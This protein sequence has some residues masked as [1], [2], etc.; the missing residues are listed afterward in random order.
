M[1]FDLSALPI[2]PKIM[3]IIG[4]ALAVHLFVI[5]VRHLVGVMLSSQKT[6]RYRK[7]QSI[8]TIATSTLMFALYFLTI[9][10]ILREFGVSLSAYLASASVIGLAIGFGSQGVVQDV[11]SGLTFIF[12]DLV[13]VGDLV[14]VSGE[15][16]VVR[17]ITM[18]F[19]QL[20]NSYGAKVFIPNRT[21]S[22]LVNYPKGYIRSIADVTL[23]GPEKQ[24]KKMHEAA[25]IAMQ[26]TYEQYP[27]ILMRAPSEVGRVKLKSGKEILR[28]KFRIWP[29]RTDPIEKFFKEEVTAE[30]TKLDA[31]YKGWMISI[32]YEAEQRITPAKRLLW[33]WGQ[34]AK[35]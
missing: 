12:S 10:F 16:G 33:G 5:V 34:N 32:S 9:G 18:R 17:A 27:G 29:D 35:A 4:I 14:K 20:E 19:I 2:V 11:V 31:N 1:N 3:V 22:T 21:V 26:N 13:D 30:L 6:K 8:S 28:M 25:L 7:L 24:R 23:T 15:T